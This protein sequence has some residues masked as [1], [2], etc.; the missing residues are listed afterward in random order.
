MHRSPDIVQNP[1]SEGQY[2]SRM[3]MGGGGGGGG[4]ALGFLLPPPQQ[5]QASKLI[6][7]HVAMVVKH[8]KLHCQNLKCT[9]TKI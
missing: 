2:V 9:K 3:G 1:L 8:N 4:G 6:N 5:K 7:K